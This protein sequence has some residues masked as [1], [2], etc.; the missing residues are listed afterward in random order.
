MVNTPMVIMWANS[1]GSITLS[2]RL[3]VQHVMPT[4][5]DNP[6]RLASLQQYLTSASPDN[7]RFS[8]SIPANGDTTQDIVFALGSRNPGSAAVD[9]ALQQHIETGRGRLD[10][11][12]Q[13]SAQSGNSQGAINQLPLLPYQR[14]VVAHG[15]FCT[16]GFLVFLPAGALIAR[17]LRTFTPTWYT[18]HW[19]SQL[20]LAGPTIVIGITL[21]V[22]STVEHL[23]DVHK[24]LGVVLLMFYIAQCG[25]GMIIHWVRSKDIRYRPP[26]NYMHAIFG[27]LIM[28]LALYQVRT[29]YH[30]EGPMTIGRE[31]PPGGMDVFWIWVNLLSITYVLGL[32]F[33]RRQYRQERRACQQGEK[34]YDD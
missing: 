20:V 28:T 2:Q 9:A 12:R 19:I 13:F 21:G 5:D 32:G 4:V 10:L 6:P 34:I 18:G 8:F 22:R 7:L 30:V 23:D 27:I 33:L 29:G 31:L 16:V 26:Q 3:A 15:I 1:D 11:T 14:L 24:R 17:Y 25:I